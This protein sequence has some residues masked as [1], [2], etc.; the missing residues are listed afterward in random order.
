MSPSSSA[1]LEC[2]H[3][4]PEFQATPNVLGRRNLRL[5][6][7]AKMTFWSLL[8]VAWLPVLQ[9]LLVGLLGALLASSRLDVLTA[10]ARRNINKVTF[11]RFS[12]IYNTTL[13]DGMCVLLAAFLLVRRLFILSSFR[14]SSSPACRVLSR[15]RTSFPG[16][17]SLAGL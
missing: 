17:S 15:S 2:L 8:V 16:S 1:S 3:C 11:S 4:D 9:V 10:D 5:P 7:K 6:A 13:N 12:C 14:R